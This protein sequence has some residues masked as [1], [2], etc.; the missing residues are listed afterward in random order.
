MR[1]SLG[2]MG[3]RCEITELQLLR[4]VQI[5]KGSFSNLTKFAK[6]KIFDTFDLS[7]SSANVEC[8]RGRRGL[9]HE[10]DRDGQE[11]HDRM[12]SRNI[13]SD[14]RAQTFML[15]RHPSPLCVSACV[16]LQLQW[17]CDEPT[18]SLG[19]VDLAD[20]LVCTRKKTCP[21]VT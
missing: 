8:K 12:C 13:E 19:A 17:S 2:V 9:S 20:F 16:K 7:S 5:G 15:Q 10:G 14:P 21:H 3:L 6:K 4:Q 18:K 11:L 1:N